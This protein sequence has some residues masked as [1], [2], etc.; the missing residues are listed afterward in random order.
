MTLQTMS[1]IFGAILLAVAILGGGFEIKEIKVS[2][3]TMGVRIVAGLV[4]LFFIG[5]GFWPQ[6][7]ALTEPVSVPEGSGMGPPRVI[8]RPPPKPAEALVAEKIPFASDRDRIDVA[9]LYVP[10]QDHKALAISHSRIG[11]ITGQANIETAK[12]G[13]LDNCRK[14]LEAARIDNKCELYA[15]D[16]VVVYQGGHPPMPPPPWYRFNPSIDQPFNSNDVPLVSES[17]RIWIEKDYHGSRKS[18]ALALSPRENAFRQRGAPSQ[19]EAARRALEACGDMAGV[20]CI[21]IAVDDVFVVRIPTT[22]KAIGFFRASGNPL[23]APGSRDDVTRRLATGT[24]GWSAVAA[25]A[26]GLAGV[27]PDAASERNA[28]EDALTDCSRHDRG[29]RVIAIGQFSVLSDEADK[30]P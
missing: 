20:A 21:I 22:M 8:S 30:A 13:A 11:M 25:G 14:A 10:A 2:N 26:N 27:V 12:K 29:C 5:L 3:V 15:V 4:G 9:A 23:I 24:S 18:K 19:D 7:S 16:N 28:I 1:F 6:P 17:T